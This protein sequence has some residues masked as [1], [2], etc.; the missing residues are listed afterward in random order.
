MWCLINNSCCFHGSPNQMLLL[1]ITNLV[2][3]LCKGCWDFRNEFPYGSVVFL[4]SRPLELRQVFSSGWLPLLLYAD[5]F[6]TCKRGHDMRLDL[7]DEKLPGT[8]VISNYEISN[9]IY[10]PTGYGR[11]WLNYGIALLRDTMPL[12]PGLPS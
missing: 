3:W 9:N 10:G 2:L 8:W 5:T 12:N 1:S 11:C 4:I 7:S 6:L